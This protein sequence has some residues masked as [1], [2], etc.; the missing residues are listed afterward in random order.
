MMD[1]SESHNE[2]VE[3]RA[4]S[5]RSASLLLVLILST[6]II[7]LAFVYFNFPKLEPEEKVH[8]KLPKSIDDAKQLGNV[9]SHYKDRYFLV[10]LFGFIVTYIF[11]QSFAIP[12]SIFLSVLSGFLFP[13]PLAIFSVC[14]CSAIGASICYLLSMLLGRPFILKYWPA[15]AAQ[16]SSQIDQHRD[17]LF[18]YIIFLRITPF[19]PNWF[20]NITSPIV[21]VP[22][23]PFFF[24]TFL[25]VAPPSFLAIHAGTTLHELSSSS[26]MII[27]L[28]S[29]L[30]LLAFAV[31]SVLPVIFKNKLK[32]R[33]KKAE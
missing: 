29:V 4:H 17:H 21:N 3:V 28:N 13:F 15:R 20:I 1:A 14:L 32:D 6:S 8:F 33:F 5:L 9:L 7:C 26:E 25:G 24:G 23:K 12:G 30:F 22:M 31:V 18:N 10:V 19:L 2:H 27:S 16:W 11:L